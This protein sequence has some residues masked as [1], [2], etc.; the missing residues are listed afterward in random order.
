[1][2]HFYNVAFEDCA[3]DDGDLLDGFANI[4]ASRFGGWDITGIQVFGGR[5][6]S[7]ILDLADTPLRTKIIAWL[8]SRPSWVEIAD[9]EHAAYFPA[10]SKRPRLVPAYVE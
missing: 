2:D 3:I 4:T 5:N 9:R 7:I 6:G 10:P 1:M 8:M